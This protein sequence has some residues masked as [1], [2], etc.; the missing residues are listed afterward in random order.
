MERK[1][2]GVEKHSFGWFIKQLGYQAPCD[3]SFPQNALIMSLVCSHRFLPPR[4][5]IGRRVSVIWS[6][7]MRADIFQ[8]IKIIPLQW[9]RI[10]NDNLGIMQAD[11]FNC[12]SAF[13]CSTFRLINSGFMF[14]ASVTSLTFKCDLIKCNLFD[15]TCLHIRKF[16]LFQRQSQAGFQFSYFHPVKQQGAGRV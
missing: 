13:Q 6:C 12:N 7:E 2:I 14:E 5:I 3:F 10:W 8:M 15:I 4:L 1:Q 9:R 11:W 16:S